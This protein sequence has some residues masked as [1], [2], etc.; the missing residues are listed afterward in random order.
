MTAQELARA[1]GFLYEGFLDVIFDRVGGKPAYHIPEDKKAAV[2]HVLDTVGVRAECIKKKKK[3]KF[4]PC[5]V[6]DGV[7]LVA[8]YDAEL[9]QAIVDRA[10][11]WEQTWVEHSSC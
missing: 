1:A 2:I 11:F 7:D 6:I 10:K 3:I 5:F 8:K 9:F 4:P